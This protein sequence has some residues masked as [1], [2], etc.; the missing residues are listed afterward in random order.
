[1]LATETPQANGHHEPATSPAPVGRTYDV[2][3]L[4]VAASLRCLGVPYVGP[5]VRPDGW[6]E[7]RFA[8]ADGEVPAMVRA[9]WGCT[10]P[11][12]QPHALVGALIELRKEL[13]AA[14]AA[15]KAEPAAGDAEGGR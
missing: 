10:L 8:D 14:R 11:E 9:Y 1:M 4:S 5:V 6:V 15:A 2:R 3:A 13:V 7:F 12:V